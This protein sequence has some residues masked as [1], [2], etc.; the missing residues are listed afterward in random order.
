MNKIQSKV[1]GSESKPKAYRGQSCFSVP[2]WFYVK[3]FL[4]QGLFLICVDGNPFL[5][6]KKTWFNILDLFWRKT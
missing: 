4:S 3:K 2:Y 5:V 6:K 1:P